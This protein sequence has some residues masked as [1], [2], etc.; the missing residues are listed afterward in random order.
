VII[1]AQL[2]QEREMNS[3]KVLREI[4]A[5]QA[6]DEARENEKRRK[7]AEQMKISTDYNFQQ[8]ERKA[9]LKAQQRAEAVATK[10]RFEDEAAHQ[11][12]LDA[13]KKKESLA[14]R[15]ELKGYLDQQVTQHRSRV[16]NEQ[17]LTDEEKQFNRSI[18]SKIEKDPEMLNKVSRAMNPQATP[19]YSAFSW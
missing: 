18:I 14:K 13:V 17:A 15:E 10:K 6:A 12:E 1:G 5:K 11:K 8:A 3:A 19:S 16:R 4:E 7:R 9:Q 2:E